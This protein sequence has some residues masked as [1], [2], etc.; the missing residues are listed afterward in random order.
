M[1]PSGRHD[2]RLCDANQVFVVSAVALRRPCQKTFDVESELPITTSSPIQLYHLVLDGG[3][4]ETIEPHVELRSLIHFYWTMQIDAPRVKLKIIPDAATDLVISSDLA[5]FAVVFLP[6]PMSLMLELAGPIRYLGVSFHPTGV[7][8]LLDADLKSL[9]KLDVGEKTIN[10]LSLQVL[11]DDLQDH[12]S[13]E[14]IRKRFDDHF[15]AA[16]ARVVHESA[17]P[18]PEPYSLFSLIHDTVGQAGLDTVCHALQISERQCRRLSTE[19]LGMSPKKLQ[20]VLR[21]QAALRELVS[22]NPALGQDLYYDDSHRIHE[23]KDLT[24][25]TPGEIRRLAEI[26][27]S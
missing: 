11:I 6:Q 12:P 22:A 13:N 4:C 10:A 7:T 9:Q 26:Y 14:V 24:G 19:L 20:R 25:L 15:L 2:G 27:N 3:R 5:D 16:R 8:A 23:L 1:L 21:L 17:S 18:T